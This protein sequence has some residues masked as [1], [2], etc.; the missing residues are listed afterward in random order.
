MSA[1]LS[2]LDSAW[3]FLLQVMSLV[4]NLYTEEPVFMSVFT[5]WIL[6]RV[7]GI[8]DLIKG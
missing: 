6:D 7:F 5:L 8:F 4:F 1:F 3:T 2:G